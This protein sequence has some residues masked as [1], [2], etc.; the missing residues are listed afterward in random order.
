MTWYADLT[1]YTHSSETDG[2]AVLNVG[3]LEAG[4]DFPTGPVGSPLRQQVFLRRL[5]TASEAPTGPLFVGTFQ[6]G[7]CTDHDA[8]RGSGEVRVRTGDGTTVLAAPT[9]VAHYVAVHDYRPPPDFVDAVC[10]G[11]TDVPGYQ[12]GEEVGRYRRD[13]PLDEEHSAIAVRA[14]ADRAGVFPEAVAPRFGFFVSHR[15]VWEQP[16]LRATDGGALPRLLVGIDR[17]GS[18]SYLSMGGYWDGTADHLVRT[19]QAS[20]TEPTLEHLREEGW[21]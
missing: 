6:C 19:V 9:L 15:L 11:R 14:L 3:W 10:A 4:R 2:A 13:E 7:L 8:T 21:H 5:G 20:V 17:S 18:R 16:G 12:P 1:P